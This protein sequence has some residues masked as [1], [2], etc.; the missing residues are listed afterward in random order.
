MNSFGFGAA[1]GVSPFSAVAQSSSGWSG[2][3]NQKLTTFEK[4]SLFSSA[5]TAKPTPPKNKATEDK[6]DDEAS[7]D[8]DEVSGDDNG[9]EESDDED[10]EAQLENGDETEKPKRNVDMRER[11]ESSLCG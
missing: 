11:L 2:W 6:P 8:D 10:L 7:D 5:T 9:A 4:K 3:D 1:T